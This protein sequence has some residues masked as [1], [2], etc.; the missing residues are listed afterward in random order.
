MRIRALRDAPADVDLGLTLVR[1]YVIATAEETNIDVDLILTV[2]PDLQ[3]FAGRYL[4]RG[5][6]LVGEDD[7]ERPGASNG[8]VGGVGIT[9]GE[10]G[11]CEMNRLWIRP[12]FRGRGRARAL[13]EASLD[14]ARVL[15]FAR[16][17]LDVV[18]QRT[19]A[20]ALY[21]SLGFTDCEPLHD[22]PFPMVC[23]G[24]DV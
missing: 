7:P 10:D 22:Y 15:G 17:V 23:L 19:G 21:R 3:D 13:C 8:V 20:I 24:R 9:P 2:V 16:M 14:A 18:P 6:F 4:D 12:P 1:E 5:A 11:L